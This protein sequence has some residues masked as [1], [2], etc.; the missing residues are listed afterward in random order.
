MRFI[1]M[2]GIRIPPFSAFIVAFFKDIDKG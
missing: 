1:W 2:V